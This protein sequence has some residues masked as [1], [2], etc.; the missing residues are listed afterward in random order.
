MSQRLEIVVAE[1]GKVDDSDWPD[2]MR[3]AIDRYSERLHSYPPGPVDGSVAVRNIGRG[4][5]WLV[6]VLVVGG[7]FFTIPE[8]HKKVRESLEEWQRIFK[9][10]KSVASW[11]V[12]TKRALYPDQYLFLVALFSLA[13]RIEPGELTFLGRTQ[14]PEDNPDLADKG[15]LLFSFSDGSVVHQVA[16]GRNGHVLWANELPVPAIGPNKSLE[17]SREG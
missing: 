15:P 14:L 17:R 13:E 2:V 8:T 16:V 3:E 10:L 9:E 6:V 11:L 7:L 12:G 1:F 5:D 4:A